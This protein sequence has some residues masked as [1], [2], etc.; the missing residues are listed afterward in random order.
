MADN[1]VHTKQGYMEG[2]TPWRGG[3]PGHIPGV[4]SALSVLNPLS[5]LSF[6]SSFSTL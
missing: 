1:S 3:V 5:T 4:L 2:G 6:L